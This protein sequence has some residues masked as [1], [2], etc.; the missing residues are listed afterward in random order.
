MD[1]ESKDNK[2]AIIVLHEIYGVN[3]FIQKQLQKFREAGYDVFCPDVRM[4]VHQLRGKR[5]LTTVE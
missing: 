4:L 2:S 1:K 3:K 5:Y